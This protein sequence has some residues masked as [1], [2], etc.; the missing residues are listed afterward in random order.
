VFG[1]FAGTAGIVA[2]LAFFGCDASVSTGTGGDGGGNTGA[3]GGQGGRDP[4]TLGLN[5]VSILVPLPSDSAPVL[6]RAADLSGDG[7]AFLPIE[8]YAPTI[9]IPGRPGELGDFYDDL[10]IV[11][12]RFDLC[13]RVKPGKCADTADSV[14]RVVYQP[15]VGGQAFDFGVHAFYSIPAA[16]TRDVVG[17]LRELADSGSVSSS[18]L[19]VNARLT[20]D[21][22]YAD[23]LRD[24]LRE[25]A[26]GDKLIRVTAM[27][28]VVIAAALRWVFH[29]IELQDGAFKE[30]VIPDLDSVTEEVLL[31]N[32]ASYQLTPEV[33]GPPGFSLAMSEQ[34]F[35]SATDAE[36]DASLRALVDI[37]NPAAHTANSVHCAACHVSTVALARRA[38]ERGV[39]PTK[40]QGR[41]TAPYDLAVTEGQ[42][43]TDDQII[44]GFGYR[45]TAIVISQ[46]VVNESAEVLLEL[47]ERFPAP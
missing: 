9:A 19:Q 43:A 1:R 28:Q 27:G 8:R 37:D 35:A 39:D 16:A 44:R 21:T 41:F 17:R 23:G 47:E 40:L 7:S 11:A 45:N 34:D 46:R 10:H 25:Y 31:L 18:P 26:L 4:R 20:S 15:I 32:N 33:D 36:K 30:I 2:A 38:E 12:V 14:L 13:D 29:G 5:D 3:A 6:F 42:S 24:L 22:A